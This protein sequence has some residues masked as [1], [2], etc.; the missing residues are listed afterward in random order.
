MGVGQCQTKRGDT[1]V[2]R[3]KGIA[4]EVP[5]VFRMV[6][7]FLLIAGGRKGRVSIECKR[8][9]VDQGISCMKSLR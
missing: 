9:Y 6:F 3:S 5:N 2:G 4:K 8:C 7:S 1:S